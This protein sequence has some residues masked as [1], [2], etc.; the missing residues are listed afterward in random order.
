[1]PVIELH[2]NLLRGSGLTAQE[3]IA[4]NALHA[5][6][7][8]PPREIRCTDLSR[9]TSVVVTVYRDGKLLGSAHGDEIPGGPARSVAEVSRYLKSFGEDLK[10]GHIVLTGSPLPL[11][12]V[13]PGDHIVVGGPESTAAE[14]FVR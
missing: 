11:Y 5:G 1:F 9:L 14:L 13:S 7:V 2:N 6:L 8:L 3:L 10:P 12:P 4:N